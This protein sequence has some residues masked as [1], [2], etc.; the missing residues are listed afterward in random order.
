MRLMILPYSVEEHFNVKIYIAIFFYAK[1][2]ICR[3]LDF[4]HCSSPIALIS[5]IALSLYASSDTWGK[6][7]KK[8]DERVSF[9][10]SA[11]IQDV[12]ESVDHFIE[13]IRY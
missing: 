7:K 9:E 8:T 5:R 12:A 11:S 13:K 10:Y 3:S 4:E 2:S 6:K 1:L